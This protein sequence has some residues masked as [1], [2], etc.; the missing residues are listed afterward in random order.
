VIG[1]G[2]RLDDVGHS[3][4][5]LVRDEVAVG[6]AFLVG[7][8]TLLTCAHV[9][10]LA[11]GRQ[12][13][14]ARRPD[15]PVTVR[16]PLV[17]GHPTV[18]A[19]VQVWQ[20]EGPDRSGDIAVLRLTGPPPPTVRPARLVTLK[21]FWGRECRTV[22]FPAGRPDGDWFSGE[23][24]GR[25]GTYRVEMA[26][27]IGRGYPIERGFSGAPVWDER[28]RGV[29]GMAV[30]YDQDL[31]RRT[32]YM[33]PSSFLAAALPRPAHTHRK[34][35]RKLV[36][37]LV[38]G[39]LAVAGL[40]AIPRFFG[41]GQAECARP[42]G[43]RVAV[44][45]A[46]L[47]TYQG[48]AGAYEKWTADHNG[49]CAT[50]SLYLYAAS[51]DLVVDPGREP[52]DGRHRLG[53]TGLH[54]DVWLPGASATA[55][56]IRR[57]DV[58]ARVSGIEPVGSTPVVLAVPAGMVRPDRDPPQRLGRLLWPD[59]F[60]M[61]ARPPGTTLDGG[62]TGTGWRVVRPDPATSQVGRLATV[63]LYAGLPDD[64]AWTRQDVEQWVEQAQDAG[65][66][67][68]GD[69]AA[70]LCRQRELGSLPTRA[71]IITTEQSLV[72]FNLGRPL[73][74]SCT[75]L[76]RPDDAT[77]LVAFYP[78]ETPVVTH[79]V[80]RLDWGDSVQGQ[81]ARQA[82]ADFAHWMAGAGAGK[83]AL[84]AQ[85]LRPAAF[86]AGAPLVDDFGARPDWPFG[87]KRGDAFGA[88]VQ[89]A[90][91]RK[92]VKAHRPGRVLVALD[93]SGSMRTATDGGRRT[94]F[95]VALDG[96]QSS[97]DHMGGDDEFGLLLFSTAMGGSGSRPVIPIGRRDPAQDT[98]LADLRR[99]VVPTGDTP[100]Y[101]AIDT[102]IGTVRASGGTSRERLGA[103][104]VLT[105]GL[106]TA[107]GPVG[108]DI[109]GG[110][111]ARVFVVAIGEASCATAELARVTQGTGGACYTASTEDV[112]QTLATLFR[113]LW[114]RSG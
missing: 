85:G 110:T 106:D 21:R 15:A 81:E 40:V 55:D 109:S 111:Q 50:A 74:G 86:G 9:V 87:H 59:L 58:G 46:G 112:D 47:A 95:E 13:R 5:V 6:V 31:N 19:L 84:V 35:P 43:L 25:V 30:A 17:A 27:E 63:A 73:G 100:L 102:G 107:S 57:S 12:P 113:T 51:P 105:D 64:P 65:G 8:R 67:P 7:P 82:A 60:R 89:Q 61:A 99:Q 88:P 24:R 14:D 75:A 52:D 53:E 94:R 70:L 114:E 92:Y 68:P 104:V 91:L 18:P 49:G 62:L 77:R 72:Q 37:L 78:A 32:G 36:P 41:G 96:V 22:G 28:K 79:V 23:L 44:P 108:P 97:L 80:V 76:G 4:A 71:A 33:I 90:A 1:Y 69:D 54:P 48:V 103:V 101:R 83:A 26:A 93:T 34:P 38:V 39:A 2:K 29:V 10:S 45:P 20:P 11:A 56:E 3:V 98:T 42:V 66:Y 16:F